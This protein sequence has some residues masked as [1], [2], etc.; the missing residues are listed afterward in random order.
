LPAV[1][2][3]T[4][5]PT[6]ENSMRRLSFVA[7]VLTAM[8]FS[9]PMAAQDEVPPVFVERVEV[10][11]VNIEVFVTDA[12]GRQ[13][14][15]LT[16][17][18]FQ[19]FEDGR[20][21]E[22]TN[23]F[24]VEQMDP[25]GEGTGE[26]GSR[27]ESSS[28]QMPLLLPADQRL[29]LVVYVDQFNLRAFNRNRALEALEEF[30]EDRIRRGD[31]VMLVSAYRGPEVVQPFTRDWQGIVAGLRKM[32]KMAT[33]RQEDE[34]RLR[35]AMK[36]MNLAAGQDSPRSAHNFVRSYIQQTLVH[37]RR[38][39]QG[40][41]DAVRSLAGLPGRKAFLYVSEGLPQRPGE[42]LYQQLLDLFG[43]NRLEDPAGMG[44]FIDP[45][46]ESLGE[47]QTRLYDQVVREANSHQVTFYTLD[48]SGAGSRRHLSADTAGTLI[49][50]DAGPGTFDRLRQ[51]NLQ[52]P[53]IEMAEAT[54]GRSILNTFDFGSALDEVAGVFDSF[55]S[56]GYRPPEGGDGRYHKIEVRLTAPGL[57]VRH[58]SGYVDKRPE[59]MIADRTISSLLFDFEKNPLGVTISFGDWIKQG[60]NEF[61]LPMIVRIPIRGVTLLPGD[62]QHEGRLRIYVVVKDEEGGISELHEAPYPV[63]V[64][65]N[66]IQQ[67]LEQ[68]IGY[69]VTLLVRPGLPKV[70]VGVWDELS[71]VDSFVH[72]QVRVGREEG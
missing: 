1:D 50:S 70:A 30:L 21:V 17:E 58:R 26:E 33:H 11:V 40:V 6:E 24:T 4:S 69:G 59:E 13:V 39:A 63:N 31:N 37:T 7:L 14:T 52:Q 66:L 43:L 47:D 72:K 28:G 60:R 68:E 42:E 34:A 25:L 54:G 71:G 18:D 65:A 48:A 62:D 64:P 10:N 16:K 20:P 9:G 8:T 51:H 5:R 49:A 45:A 19:V 3:F 67:A 2:R 22:I 53:L 32:R 29:S 23:F 15:G 61:E 55:Y 38:S 35:M 27:E 57:T 41:R 36:S 44:Q 12:A 56:L 46:I